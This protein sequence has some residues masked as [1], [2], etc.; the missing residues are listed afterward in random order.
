[1]HGVDGRRIACPYQRQTSS[2]SKSTRHHYTRQGY[3][4]LL[5][6]AENVYRE[7]RFFASRA[8]HVSPSSVMEKVSSP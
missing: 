5:E 3:T 8:L 6:H 1:M 2:S 4:Q 7:S